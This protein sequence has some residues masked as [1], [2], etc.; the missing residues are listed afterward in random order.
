MTVLDYCGL[1]EEKRAFMRK[2]QDRDFLEIQ[3]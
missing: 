2:E 1:S 3:K